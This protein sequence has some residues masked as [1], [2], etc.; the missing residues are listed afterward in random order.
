MSIPPAARHDIASTEWPPAVQAALAA[1]LAYTLPKDR[2]CLE[3]CPQRS[4]QDTLVNR[5]SLRRLL[6]ER[7][8]SLPGEI[9]VIPELIPELNA[10]Q[11][12][13]PFALP[14]ASG[15]LGGAYAITFQG[16][17]WT[18]LISEIVRVLASDGVF[19]VGTGDEIA[20]DIN[21]H[22]EVGWE[23]ILRRNAVELKAEVEPRDQLEMALKQSSPAAPAAE[24]IAVCRW[25]GH[26]TPRT[27]L[28]AMKARRGTNNLHIGEAIFS[29][30]LKDYERWL[31]AQYG[32]LN[33]PLVLVRECALNV[34]RLSH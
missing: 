2:P 26:F 30:C 7:G 18:V 24:V 12:D 11:K 31:K 27:R 3:L 23:T 10:A 19:V 14:F 5:L 16:L 21:N 1:A 34:W 22:M 4:Q 13:K 8:I 28:E 6:A 25:S 33:A 20:T 29:R 17:D 15:S 32:D 9:A